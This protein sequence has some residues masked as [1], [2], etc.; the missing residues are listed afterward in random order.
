M[1][2]RFI[3]TLMLLLAAA[4]FSGD[5]ARVSAENHQKRIKFQITTIGESE[6]QRNILAQTTVEGLPGTDF[7]INLETGNFRMKTRF[8]T[9]LVA[10]D[11]LKIRASLD[12]QRFYGYSPANLPLYE[13]DSQKQIMELGFGET[14][15]LLPF[16]RGGAA[17]TLKIEITPVLFLVP[18]ASEE[19]Q[20][21][22][23]NFDKRLPSGEIYIEASKIPHRF[24]VEAALLADGR[25]IAQGTGECLLEEE[26]GIVLE[27]VGENEKQGYAVK[28]TVDKFS[29]NRPQD[30]VGINFDFYR[31]ES[32]TE[33]MSNRIISNGAGVGR[34]GGELVY[35]LENEGNFE[36]AGKY[37]LRFKIRLAEGKQGN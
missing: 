13:E 35:R 14:V 11:K 19:A 16:G 33:S 26:K 6:N 31:A 27:P 8:L 22:K 15:V 24:V 7:N 32:R 3:F 20:K 2:T 29:R 30:S 28:L 18:Q 4:A 23:I 1:T 5:R 21:L 10:E 17:E 9:D 36:E 25:E 37:E 34:L 12:T